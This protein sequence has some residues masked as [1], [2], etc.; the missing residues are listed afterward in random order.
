MGKY[1]GFQGTY[2]SEKANVK[3][4]LDMIFFEEDGNHIVYCPALDLCGYGKT[5]SEASE[6]F[7]IVLGEFFTYTIHKNTLRKVLGDM[8][9]TI[10]TSKRK[11]MYPPDMTEL[12][13]N[14]DNFSRIFNN[15]DFR[16]TS[17]NFNI[18]ACA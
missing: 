15:H 14:N 5:E 11:P 1:G 17:E 7:K 6:S 13:K 2:H 9:W 4:N 18:P 16:K 12:L 10:K 8:G 3:V